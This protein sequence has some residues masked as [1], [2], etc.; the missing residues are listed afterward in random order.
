MLN[1]NLKYTIFTRHL[2]EN[3]DIIILHNLYIF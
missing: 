2:I 1:Y 3:N